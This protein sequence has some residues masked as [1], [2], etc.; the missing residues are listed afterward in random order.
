LPTVCRALGIPFRETHRAE[1]DARAAAEIARRL[2]IAAEPT[3][4]RPAERVAPADR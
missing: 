4:D 3:I 1:A 2:V